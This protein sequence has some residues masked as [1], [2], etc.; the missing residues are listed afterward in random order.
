[1]WSLVLRE[2]SCQ[3]D[4]GWRGGN[5]TGVFRGAAIGW[6]SSRLFRGMR[7]TGVTPMSDRGWQAQQFEEHRSH[8]RAIAYRMLGSVTEAEDAVQEAWLRLDRAGENGVQNMRAWL[9]TVVGRV[10]IDMLRARKSRHEDFV[11]EWLPEPVVGGSSDA[12]DPEQQAL[13]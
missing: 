9:T 10:C 3:L 6:G 5:V 7:H 11:G 4:D 8:L 2:M 13:L 12:D 1:Q